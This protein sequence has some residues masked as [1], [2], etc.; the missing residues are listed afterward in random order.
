MTRKLDASN[1]KQ[2]QG[3]TFRLVCLTSEALSRSAE[4]EEG[5]PWLSYLFRGLQVIT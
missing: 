3:I 1:N 5:Q 4:P 2:F